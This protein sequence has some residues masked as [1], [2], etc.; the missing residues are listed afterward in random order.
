MK[1]CKKCGHEWLP[2]VKKPKECPECKSRSWNKNKLHK[3]P[4]K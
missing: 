1:K 4:K 2:R 3:T